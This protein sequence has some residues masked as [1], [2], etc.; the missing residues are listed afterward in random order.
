MI[1]VDNDRNVVFA[2]AFD[3]D[4]FVDKP[5]D[6]EIL[7]AI[8]S[9]NLSNFENGTVGIIESTAGPLMF[10][11]RPILTSEK[12]G[13]S[14]GIL[15]ITRYLNKVQIDNLRHSTGLNFDLVSLENTNLYPADLTDKN[16]LVSNEDDKVVKGYKV[17]KD[18]NDKPVLTIVL[19]QNRDL[20]HQGQRTA[21]MLMLLVFVIGVTALTSAVFFIDQEAI[22]PIDALSLQVRQ[23]SNEQNLSKRLNNL[24]GK[25]FN[26]LIA[27]F[28]RML[29]IVQSTENSMKE[30]NKKLLEKSNELEKINRLMV[31]REL[32]MI[33]LKQELAE[34][35]EK[36]NDTNRE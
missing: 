3:L 15:I 14:R 19:A 23:I 8:P 16:V 22:L 33:N 4:K 31:N 2:K 28:N 12:G 5:V 17:L 36:L 20:Y 13:P 34:L 29:D 7:E 35:K 1:F 27:D 18:I 24:K 10:S 6:K 25:E 30:A 26:S 21:N 32:K 11:A 9:I